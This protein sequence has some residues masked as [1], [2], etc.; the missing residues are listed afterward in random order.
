MW[1]LLW[2]QGVFFHLIY[3]DI[4]N[5]NSVFS[6]QP[7]HSKLSFCTVQEVLLDIKMSTVL[8]LVWEKKCM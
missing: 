6:Y 3:K 8:I 5:K 2:L 1:N 4:D 7:I